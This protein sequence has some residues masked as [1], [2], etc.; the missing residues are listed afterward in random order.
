MISHRL[1]TSCCDLS[2]YLA[3]LTLVL[4]FKM[5]ESATSTLQTKQ[6][7]SSMS[8]TA[9][10]GSFTNLIYLLPWVT[11]ETVVKLCLQ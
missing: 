5:E 7:M 3:S 6:S 2:S 1:F 10:S 9:A 4:I 11:E 8:V